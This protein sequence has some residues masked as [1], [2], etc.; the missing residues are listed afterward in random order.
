[1]ISIGQQASKLTIMSSH[2]LITGKR[3]KINTVIQASFQIM[4]WF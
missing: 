3:D 4:L 2:Y 1:M